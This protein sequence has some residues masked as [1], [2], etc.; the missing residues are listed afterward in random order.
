MG[1][2]T[3]AK[4]AVEEFDLEHLLS[5]LDDLIAGATST[6]DEGDAALAIRSISW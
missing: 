3:N 4:Q 5:E 6:E 1:T 2:S